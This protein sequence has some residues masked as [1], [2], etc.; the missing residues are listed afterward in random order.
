MKSL[1]HV[2]FL[3]LALVMLCLAACS[4]ST[5]IVPFETGSETTI[6]AQKVK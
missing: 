3:L 6:N 4:K 1:K 5:Y 2:F